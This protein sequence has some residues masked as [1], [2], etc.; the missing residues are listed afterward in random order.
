MLLVLLGSLLLLSSCD[1]APPVSPIREC[2][3]F[4]GCRT[5]SGISDV[6]AEPFAV[7]NAIANDS[8]LYV[9]LSSLTKRFS[10][11]AFDPDD[12]FIMSR[13]IDSPETPGVN[14][15]STWQMDRITA[16]STVRHGG[17]EGVPT[18]AFDAFG[19]VTMIWGELVPYDDTAVRSPVDRIHQITG[20]RQFWESSTSVRDLPA[21][22]P[23]SLSG[24]QLS[25]S[26]VRSGDRLLSPFR[27]VDETP[28]GRV[29]ILSRWENEWTVDAS[30]FSGNT[31]SPWMDRNAHNHL[32]L[33]YLKLPFIADDG[34]RGLVVRISEDG[35]A[36]WSSEVEVIGAGTSLESQFVKPEVPNVVIANDGTVHAVFP[37]KTS[38]GRYFADQMWHS[39]SVDNGKTWSSPGPIFSSDTGVT[40]PFDAVV[41]PAGRL[42]VVYY[43]SPQFASAT[44][45][46]LIHAVWSNGAWRPSRVLSTAPLSFDEHQGVALAVDPYGCVHAVWDE[47]TDWDSR[48]SQFQYER[49]TCDTESD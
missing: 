1:T 33:A 15:D 4:E 6:R 20:D 41:D 37:Y 17:Q 21:R 19:R 29:N 9:S 36:T 18:L 14:G 47:I 38:S 32:A 16:D 22:S 23:Q 40:S 28:F 46:R 5:L 44:G 10:G 42:H 7:S 12:V 39:L 34:P 35:G 25:G 11:S 8:V 48:T 27:S 30:L 2:E 13:R 3:T 24:P 43:Q 26:L 49:L 45:N 31:L